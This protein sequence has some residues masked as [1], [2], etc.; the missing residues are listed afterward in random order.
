MTVNKDFKRLVRARMLK[1]GETYTTAR[2]RLLQKQSQAKPVEVDYATLAGMSDATI[3]TRTGCTWKRWVGALDYV[4][5]HKWSHTEIATYVYEKF[6]IDGWWAQSVTVGYERIKGLRAIGQRRDGSYEASKT[7]VFNT[8][9]SKVYQ[10]WASA[11]TR[12]RWLPDEFTVST[13]TRNKSLRI[14]WP[15]GSNVAVY[16]Y[17]KGK[18]KAQVNVQ[19][20]KLNKEGQTSMRTFWQE[21]L[22]NLGRVL[23]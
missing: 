23:Q 15:D 21:K 7:R 5:A 16:F 4:G 2:S 11:K 6:K 17:S 10:A 20:M 22:E 19:H 9:I 12:A 3:K 18:A 1:T 13:A 8:P 14:K